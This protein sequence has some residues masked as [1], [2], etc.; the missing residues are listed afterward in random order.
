[1]SLYSWLYIKSQDLKNAVSKVPKK[2]TTLPTSKE[3]EYLFQLRIKPGRSTM[4]FQKVNNQ[5]AKNNK[6]NISFI[7]VI[8]KGIYKESQEKMSTESNRFSHNMIM[9][10]H[11]LARKAGQK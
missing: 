9:G 6:V 2:Q 5:P 11:L 8:V 4:T 10:H 1:V 7:K 3:I